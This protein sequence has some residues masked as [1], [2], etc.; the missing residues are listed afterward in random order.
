MLCI[1]VARKVGKVGKSVLSQVTA[2]AIG[3]QVPFIFLLS[4]SVIKKA[5]H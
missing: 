1:F 2:L 5:E 3:V 4:C